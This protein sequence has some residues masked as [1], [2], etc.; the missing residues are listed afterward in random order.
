MY[1]QKKI[2]FRV[3]DEEYHKISFM[4][5]KNGQTISGYLKQLALHSDVSEAIILHGKK[6]YT[7]LLNLHQEVE[8]MEKKDTSNKNYTKIK[9]M[10]E[11]ITYELL[12]DSKRN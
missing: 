2:S 9:E 12:Q 5:E 6:I 11:D 8:Q 1:G 7:E 10:V 3:T 4:A